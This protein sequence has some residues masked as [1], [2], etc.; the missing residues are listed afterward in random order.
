MDTAGLLREWYDELHCQ[1]KVL[2]TLQLLAQCLER[3]A[4]VMTSRCTLE[5]LSNEIMESV[6]DLTL[7][8]L[9]RALQPQPGVCLSGLVL[10]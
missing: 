6:T 7:K 1:I 4:L 8:P 10:S 3:S 9:A 2:R 5:M